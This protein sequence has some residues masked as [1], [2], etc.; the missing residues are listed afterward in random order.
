MPKTATHSCA[1]CVTAPPTRRDARATAFSN[2]LCEIPLPTSD[3][4]FGPTNTLQTAIPGARVH[5]S[6][7]RFAVV[8]GA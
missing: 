1:L 6:N 2:P 5:S 4:R 8:R 3:S 7:A